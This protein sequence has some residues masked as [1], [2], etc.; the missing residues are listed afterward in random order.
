MMLVNL[1]LTYFRVSA[2]VHRSF[3]PI[4]RLLHVTHTTECQLWA[5]WALANLTRVYRK[6]FLLF[7]TCQHSCVNNL[8]ITGMCLFFSSAEKYVMILVKE[9]G[10]DLLRS[11]QTEDQDVIEFAKITLQQ[12][13]TFLSIAASQPSSA[14]TNNNNKQM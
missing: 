10:L 9:G 6:F 13:E 7:P 2:F 1:S 5:A 14:A 12:S 3:E 4:L 11:L 8:E